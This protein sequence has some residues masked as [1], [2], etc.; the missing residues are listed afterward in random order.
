MLALFAKSICTHCLP[1]PSSTHEPSSP[2]L[3]PSV[4]RSSVPTTGLLSLDVTFF[5][6]ARLTVPTGTMKS[7][8]L[9]FVGGSRLGTLSGTGVPTNR[10]RG[11]WVLS[12][13]LSCA[14][15]ALETTTN[16]AMNVQLRKRMVFIISGFHFFAADQ[17]LLLGPHRFVGFM[18]DVFTRESLISRAIQL[19]GSANCVE[20]ILEVRLMRG[21]IEEHGNLVLCELRGFPHVYFCGVGG[22][23][24][25]AHIAF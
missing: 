12:G 3:S 8:R 7:G 21:F 18:N 5:A 2:A 9:P 22:Y 6:L 13:T 14:R 4:T 10:G 24:N 11:S 16:A 19:R 15:A 20:E 17:K 25:C 23:R 1:A